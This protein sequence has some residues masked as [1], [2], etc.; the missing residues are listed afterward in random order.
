MHDEAP[1]GGTLASARLFLSELDEKIEA[2]HEQARIEA[3]ARVEAERIATEDVRL[4]R[5]KRAD[6]LQRR[7]KQRDRRRSRLP[8]HRN[9]GLQTPR[10]ERR[11]KLRS[12]PKRKQKQRSSERYEP[13]QRQKRER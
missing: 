10:R 7:Q 4:L 5:L 3:V 12:G 9:S 13:K 8:S 6:L 11:Q 1:D 2:L